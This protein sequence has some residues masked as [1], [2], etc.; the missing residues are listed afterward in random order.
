[1]NSAVIIS[2]LAVTPFLPKKETE[3]KQ[4]RHLSKQAKK[5]SSLLSLAVCSKSRLELDGMMMMMVKRWWLAPYSSSTDQKP[6][7]YLSFLFGLH[8]Y[9]VVM[10]LLL[11]FGF[12]GSLCFGV[13]DPLPCRKTYAMTILHAGLNS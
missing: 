5:N 1:M 8:A 4:I 11:V 7:H 2:S 10:S 13:G 6:K 12:I 3:K 9:S